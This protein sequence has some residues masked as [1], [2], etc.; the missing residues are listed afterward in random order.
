MPKLLLTSIALLALTACPRQTK[1]VR[2]PS[3]PTFPHVKLPLSQPIKSNGTYDVALEIDGVAQ[4]CTLKITGM[5]PSKTEK[6]GGQKMTRSPTTRTDSTCKGFGV[7][8]I[9]SEGWIP[10]FRVDGTPKK[11]SLTMIQ[12]DKMPVQASADLE[13][14]PTE[15]LGKGC[16]ETQIA[17]LTLTL[18]A[19]RAAPVT[20][21]KLAPT[22]TFEG[23]IPAGA[24]EHH[25]VR[26]QAEL[27]AL[28]A[29]LPKFQISKGPRRPNPDPMIQG[30]KLDFS[31]EMLLVGTCPTFYCD[32]EMT[33]YEVRGD[34]MTVFLKLPPEPK[35]N[36]MLQRPISG[37]SGGDSTGNYLGLVVPK[38]EGKVVFVVEK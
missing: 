16:G 8:G 5:G 27:D 4:S 9:M 24:K 18:D 34:T 19:D 26:T 11:V 35:E 3:M 36:H 38:F 12:G 33:E 31:K 30:P 21:K 2:C 32:V 17:T 22:Q 1:E 14:K 7:S 20:R 23:R 29:V 6:M 37:P 10:G 15:L 28:I 13:Y 25:A